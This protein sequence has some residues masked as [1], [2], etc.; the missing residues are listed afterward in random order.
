MWLLSL[1]VAPMCEN[2]SHYGSKVNS[3]FTVPRFNESFHLPGLISI[4]RKQ[5]LCVSQ[6]KMYPIY[7]ASRIT[8]PNSFPGKSGFYCIWLYLLISMNNVCC[9]FCHADP[10]YI[11]T[12]FNISI[13]EASFVRWSFNLSKLQI[14]FQVTRTVK[15]GSTASSISRSISPIKVNH[16]SLKTGL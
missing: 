15:V 9:R 11:Y 10:A 2:L 4:P 7:R 14:V 12:W 16:S 6:R 8:R 5:A 3:R 1:C 13:N